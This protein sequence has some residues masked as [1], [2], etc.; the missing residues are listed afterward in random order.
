MVY[1]AV[2]CLGISALNDLIKEVLKPNYAPSFGLII[3]HASVVSLSLRFSVKYNGH[4]EVAKQ[5]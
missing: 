1:T 3:K 2:G 5:F 4:L